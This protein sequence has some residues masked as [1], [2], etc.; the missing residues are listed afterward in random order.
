MEDTIKAEVHTSYDYDEMQHIVSSRK[1]TNISRNE[2]S[3]SSVQNR[4]YHED[5]ARRFPRNV[6]I[7][8]PNDIPACRHVSLARSINTNVIN[9]KTSNLYTHEFKKKYVS[10][11]YILISS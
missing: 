7:S 4:Y 2:L 11:S 3:S 6:C 8:Q 9:S 1:G 10:Y 5:G